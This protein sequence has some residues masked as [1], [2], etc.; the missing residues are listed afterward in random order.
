MGLRRGKPSERDTSRA[1][2]F[3][4]TKTVSGAKP[5]AGWMACDPYW[6]ECHTS[7][8]GTKPCLKW[9]TSGALP[10]PRCRPFVVPTWLAY[11]GVYREQDN[12][13]VCVI[14]H[15]SAADL[16]ADL[17]YPH[18]V[19]VGREH[20]DTASVYIRRALQPQPLRS[21]R[22]SRS[23]PADLAAS[24]LTMWGIAELT[25]WYMAQ[26]RSSDTAVSLPNGIAVK[27]DGAPYGPMSQAAAKRA[28]AKVVDEAPAPADGSG[29]VPDPGY[30]K[31]V[32]RLKANAKPSTNGHPKPKG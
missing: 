30:E 11:C 18:Y 19:M 4:Y 7:D 31:I 20:G 32:N 15:E 28:G 8:T 6:C 29:T 26:P 22:V 10:C 23:R 27:D 5:W 21:L 16:L 3:A 17:T 9:I 24:L 25:A 13:P 2:Q 14:V 1:E 12:K